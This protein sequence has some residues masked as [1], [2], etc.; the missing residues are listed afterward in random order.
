METNHLQQLASRRLLTRNGLLQKM[1]VHV[2]RNRWVAI[3]V[4]IALIVLGSAVTIPLLIPLTPSELQLV[5]IGQIDTGEIASCVAVGGDIAFVLDRTESVGSLVLVN[6]SDPT[7]P[8]ELSRFGTGGEPMELDVVND[9]V[10][11]ADF[12]RGLEI[13]DV[14]DPL[15]PVQVGEYVGSGCICDVQVIDD[16]VFV[17]DVSQLLN[18]FFRKV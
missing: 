14:S 7:N 3:A 2:S 10:Y 13:V 9:I 11:I 4:G 6:I 18:L 15:N 8:T 17:A 12:F 1:G 16:L 5:E